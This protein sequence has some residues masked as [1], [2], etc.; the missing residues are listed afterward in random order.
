MGNKKPIGIFDS[1]LGGLTVVKAV[2]QELPNESIVYFGDTARVPYGNKSAQLIKEYSL[3]I[4]NFLLKY[5]TKI[6]IIACN[7]ATALA[8]NS[9]EKQL[10]I[11]VIGVIKPGVNSALK[12]TRNKHIGIIGT[13]STIDSGIYKKNIKDY[14]NKI[15]VTSTPCPLFVPLAEEGWLNEPA[16]KLIAKKYLQTINDANA[17]TLILGCTHYPILAEVIKSVLSPQT[18]LVDSAQA[19]AIDTA[20]LLKINGLLSEENAKGTLKLF[21]SDLPARFED[22]AT[23][24]LGEKIPDVQKIQLSR[25]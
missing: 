4:A 17:D 5:D 7:T 2:R 15:K 12:L 20:K 14:D 13:I 6:I 19:I 11:P 18:K 1:G 10:N 3:E 8:L 16:T 21:V 23:R 24:F 25:V 9:L 22:V